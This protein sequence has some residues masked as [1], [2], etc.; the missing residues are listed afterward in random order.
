MELI[1]SIPLSKIRKIELYQNTGRR[2]MSDIKQKTGADYIINGGIYSFNTFKPFGN[3]KVNGEVVYSPGYGE[4]GY[5]W[6]IGDDITYEVLPS[7][8]ANYI[9]CVGMV[10]TGCKQVLR[11]NKDMGGS[12]QRSAIGLCDGNLML[13]CCNGIHSKTPEK[14]QSYVFNKGWTSALM[15]DGGGSTQAIFDGKTLASSENGGRGRVVQNYILVYLEKDG[16]DANDDVCKVECPYTEPTS[17]IRLWSRGE[18]AKW[19]QWMLNHVAGSQL[20]VDG[21]FGSKSVAALKAFQ[22]SAGLSVDGL[23]GKNTRAALKARL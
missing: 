17:T 10:L 18:G 22:K 8:K 3:V 13:Y 16:F 23:S 15:L 4:Y 14:L 7:K 19:T 12:R 11:Y 5:A 6:D 20:D 9:G 21:I 2:Y 1:A